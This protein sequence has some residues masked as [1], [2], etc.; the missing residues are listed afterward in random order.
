ME[1]DEFWTS[2]SEAQAK[3]LEALDLVP[4]SEYVDCEHAAAG[5]LLCAAFENDPY[6]ILHTAERAL[7]IILDTGEETLDEEVSGGANY[8]LFAVR[9]ALLMLAETFPRYKDLSLDHA[10]AVVSQ[11]MLEDALDEGEEE[12]D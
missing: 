10:R 6:D 7:E 8:S 9:G 11:Q 1:P 12:E 4:Q 2:L 3:Y 5:A